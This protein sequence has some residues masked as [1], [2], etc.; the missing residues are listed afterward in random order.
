MR[1]LALIC[2]MSPAQAAAEGWATDAF[3]LFDPSLANEERRAWS[4]HRL[5]E[6]STTPGPVEEV[7]LFVGPKS[8]VAGEDDGHAVS[9]L[10]DRDGNL[11]ANDTQVEMRVDEDRVT[12]ETSRGIADHLFQPEPVSGTLALGATAG[13][14]QSAR[15][16]ARVVANIGTVAPRLGSVNENIRYEAFFELSADG[17][18]DAY[19]NV[20][21]DGTYAR[22]V[23]SHLDGTHSLMSATTQNGTATARFLARDIGT[24][25]EA[26][27]RIGAALT[28]RGQINI[29]PLLA[30]GNLRAVATSVPSIRSTRIEIGPFGTDAGYALP[31]GADVTAALTGKDGTLHTVSGWVQDGVFTGLFPAA[32]LP[33]VPVMRVETVLGQV[34]VPVRIEN[35]QRRRAAE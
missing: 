35:P 24:E 23:L 14:I 22:F 21:D 13:A 25:A 32:D 8:L 16:T 15:A 6:P 4:G 27:A 29:Q 3:G 17:M 2:F 9:I 5:G 10:L 1:I 12:V 33:D 7:L 18:N 20:L 19:G 28:D 31:D 11:A 34:D 30:A 26:E